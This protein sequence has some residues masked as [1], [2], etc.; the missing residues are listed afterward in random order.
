MFGSSDDITLL[1]L[2]LPPLDPE[3]NKD[4][5]DWHATNTNNENTNE[6]DIKLFD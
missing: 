3:L 5:Q 2:R 6:D 1:I 4:C